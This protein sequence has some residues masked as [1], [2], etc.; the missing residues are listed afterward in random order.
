M[1]QRPSIFSKRFFK[2]SSRPYS[3]R[4]LRAFLICLFISFV[5]WGFIKISDDYVVDFEVPIAFFNARPTEIIASQ[6]HQN[7]TYRL[8]A[9]GLKTLLNRFSPSLDTLLIDVRQAPRVTKN[10]N[11]WAYFTSNQ[12][13]LAISE[14]FPSDR[15]VLQVFPDTVFALVGRAFEKN[16]PVSVIPELTFQK[17]FG[18]IGSILAEPDSVFVKGP[19]NIIDTISV[20]E[21]RPLK[22][23]NLASSMAVDLP[24]ASPFLPG[25][26]QLSPSMV[27]VSLLVAEFSEASF[28]MPVRIRYEKDFAG[29]PFKI[30]LFPEKVKVVCLIPIRLFASFD[31]SFLHA[32]IMAPT[33]IEELANF[34]VRVD[35]FNDDVR[36]QSIVPSVVEV[37]I[38]ED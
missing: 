19:R 13:R 28:D 38:L 21:T 6:S 36:V 14:L 16:V 33:K 9:N 25:V 10:D 32:F 8:K 15:T 4:N 23:D 20:I 31:Q 29:K 34:E 26:L 5:A 2:T 17:G 24:L 12:L 7:V 27:K 37:I 18:L 3:K 30:K 35:S 1:V 22:L 11:S